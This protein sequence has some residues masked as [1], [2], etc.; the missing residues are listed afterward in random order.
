VPSP[1]APVAGA[2]SRPPAAKAAPQQHLSNSTAALI[3]AIEPGVALMGG[4]VTGIQTL[5]TIALL[6]LMHLSGGAL[7]HSRDRLVRQVRG[8]TAPLRWLPRPA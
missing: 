5:A 8:A 7:A 2:T 4:A 3:M 1:L 6:G